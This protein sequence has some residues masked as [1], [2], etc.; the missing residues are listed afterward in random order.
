MATT[1]NPPA[2]AT[3]GQRRRA[4]LDRLMT[5]PWK[6]RARR[7]PAL[8]KELDRRGLITPH[9]SWTSY[10][11]TDGTPV[12]RALRANAIRLHWRLE[13]LR[14]RLGDVPIVVDG[15]YRTV[16]R[17]RQVGGAEG[18]R[19]THADGADFF[20]QQ[21]ERWI[22][23]GRQTG[24]GA[25]SRDDVLRIASRTFFNGGVGNENSGTLHLDARGFKARFVTWI[26]G[27]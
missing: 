24:R 7:S 13:L 15:P 8:R 22:A 17:N 11:G 4:R 18:S 19:H 26:P 21:V 2:G 1:Q 12:P 16:A 3:L 23:H 20:V 25:K 9:F 10:A 27:R 6:A 14:H 5:K